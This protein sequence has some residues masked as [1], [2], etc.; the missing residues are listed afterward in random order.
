MVL[1]TPL[2]S[3]LSVVAARLP[4]LVARVTVLPDRPAM[5]LVQGLLLLLQA[6]TVTVLGRQARLAL[7][8]DSS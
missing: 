1:A 8:S 6:V 3:R 4:A 5:A 2:A 7:G